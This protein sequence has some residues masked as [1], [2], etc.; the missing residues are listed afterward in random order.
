LHWKN[1]FD[2]SLTSLAAGQPAR[3]DTPLIGVC[4]WSGLGV[5]ARQTRQSPATR[6]SQ[7]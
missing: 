3:Q 5:M 1:L 7:K 4:V 6:L 2:E